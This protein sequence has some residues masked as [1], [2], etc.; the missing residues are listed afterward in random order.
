LNLLSVSKNNC[1]RLQYF[2]YDFVNLAISSALALFTK[3][4]NY[5]KV[6]NLVLSNQFLVYYTLRPRLFISC[7]SIQKTGQI[8]CLTHQIIMSK[9]CDVLII[10]W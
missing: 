7:G 5:A 1:W 2:L 9:F 10:F 6:K 4:N 3:K 8:F